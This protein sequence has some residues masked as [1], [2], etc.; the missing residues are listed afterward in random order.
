MHPFAALPFH[1]KMINKSTKGIKSSDLR[2]LP[3]A[4]PIF[5]NSVPLHFNVAAF[6]SSHQS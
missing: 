2:M 1:N 5:N 6:L 4:A 3:S